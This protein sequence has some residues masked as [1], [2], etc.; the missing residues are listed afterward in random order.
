M[1][2]QLYIS[3]YALIDSLNIVWSDGF[4]VI[5]GETGA[6]KSI[7]LGAL[8]MVLG[9]RADAKNIKAGC[10]KCVVEATF[11]ISKLKLQ[12]F[13]VANDI[14]YDENE[15]I[16]RREITSNGKSRSFIN[17][18][19]IAVAKLKEISAKIIDIHSQ[20][21]N[22]LMCNEDFLI[23]TL[24]ILAGNAQQLLIYRNLLHSWQ[25][26]RNELV[27][28]QENAIKNKEEI[29]F[30][31]YQVQQLEEANLE[32]SE[33]IELEKELELLEH[34]EEIKTAL[35][36][37]YSIL[38]DGDTSP[39]QQIKHQIHALEGIA[40]HYPE[41]ELIVERLE[42][43]KIE[44]EDI[45]DELSRKNDSIEFDPQRL[46]FV[47]D[48]LSTIYQLEKK[49]RV[50]TVEELVQIKEELSKRI[51]FIDN[52]DAIILEKR[53]QVEQLN[54]QLH[55][56]A[57][58]ISEA[59]RGQAKKLSESLC[60]MLAD[61]GMPNAQVEIRFEKRTEPDKNGFDKPR[62]LFSANKELAVR[63]VSEIA[64]GGEIAR[65]MLALKSILAT[66]ENLPTIVFDEIDTGV[67]GVMA[68]KMAKVM[69]Q[70]SNSCQV[71]CITHLPQIAALGSHHYK[72]FK[73]E[74]GDATHSRLLKLSF[75][76]R[77]EEI[78]KMLSGEHISD[79]A[80]HNAQCLLKPISSL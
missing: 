23:N 10:Q 32:V 76:E 50:D 53:L 16:I 11:D 49:F 43:V 36:Q 25:K 21:Q 51:D 38:A 2:K 42:S 30:L 47:T 40:A 26:N 15:C 33:Q 55:E 22:L 9:N 61:L 67:S 3:N 14:D 48:R 34:A 66:H 72:V 60:S 62:F 18:S 46:S 63:D 31:Q 44:L 27:V 71:I 59:R 6:G 19:P 8:G 4:S 7:L 35:Y 39:Q 20:H 77:V 57:K 73:T 79:A 45:T 52:S 64:S 69:Q 17:D 5:T 37:S 80:I 13:F 78:A 58:L 68:E 75:A 56:C 54:S 70:M 74:D 65:L 41:A 1:L 24:D 29:D 12:D 28:L